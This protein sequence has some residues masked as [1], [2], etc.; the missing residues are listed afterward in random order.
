MSSVMLEGVKALSRA[1]E[2]R[3]VPGCFYVPANVVN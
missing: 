3:V 2:A 1:L